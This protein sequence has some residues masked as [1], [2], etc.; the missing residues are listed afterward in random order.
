VFNAAGML[1]ADTAWE[2]WEF[3]GVRLALGEH[4]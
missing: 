3:S 4:S 1:L 2:I